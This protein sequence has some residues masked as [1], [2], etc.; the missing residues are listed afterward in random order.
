MITGKCLAKDLIETITEAWFENT[1]EW[2]L[3]ETDWEVINSWRN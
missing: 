1:E 2:K 3:D